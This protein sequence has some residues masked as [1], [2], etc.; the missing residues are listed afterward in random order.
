[1]TVIADRAQWT[2]PFVL[3]RAA[4]RFGDRPF[5]SFALGGAR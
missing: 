2:L 1:M 4:E 5:L 3:A